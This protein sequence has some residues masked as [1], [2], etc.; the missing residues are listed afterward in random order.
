MKTLPLL[1]SLCLFATSETLQ[2]GSASWKLNPTSGDWNTT[3][4]W[5]PET[6]P[7]NPADVATFGSSNTNAISLSAK[8]QV[9]SVVFD[10]N[11]S[12]F[13]VSTAADHLTFFGTGIVNNSGNEQNFVTGL[14]DGG[15]INFR[16]NA[17]A[18]NAVFTVYGDALQ[19]YVFF[20]DNAK[21]GDATFIQKGG[22][23]GAVT[24]FF[25]SS[26]A[27]N[28]TFYNFTEGE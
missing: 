19:P 13:T 15:T 28:A 23:G 5:T 2:A 12:A 20:H 1:C 4:N 14:Q 24:W 10:A 17:S 22:F 25:D 16:N 6:V 7:N 11:A 8:T 18:G 27:G 3:A 26:T 9:D 21:A